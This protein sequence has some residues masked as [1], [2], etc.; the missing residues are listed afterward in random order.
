MN[1]I[2]NNLEGHQFVSENELEWR[3]E[4][5]IEK[6]K[7]QT[8]GHF[9]VGYNARLIGSD[10]P[11]FIKVLDMQSITTRGTTGAA[12]ALDAAT[13]EHSFETEILKICKERKLSRVLHATDAGLSM[14]TSGDLNTAFLYIAFERANLGAMANV[15]P[16]IRKDGIQY[17]PSVCHNLLVGLQQL[18]GVNIHHN[19]IK[20]SNIL[21]FDM[22]LQKIGDLG[23]STHPTLVPPFGDDN[24][25]AGDMS[26]MPPETMF[27]DSIRDRPRDISEHRLLTDIYMAGSTLFYAITD[28]PYNSLLISRAISNTTNI[29]DLD[30][31]EAMPHL[32]NAHFSIFKDLQ[33]K[34]YETYPRKVGDLLKDIIIVISTISHPDFKVRRTTYEKSGLQRIISKFDLMKNKMR[35]NYNRES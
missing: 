31:D 33:L 8:G 20:P 7:S 26:Y 15:L 25:H 21:F 9:S 14:V 19:D 3:F 27:S 16:E 30:Y 13:K 11:Y 18:H 10:R 17:F 35:V 22:T 1:D 23:R 28:T 29:L 24:I 32:I 6:Q 5:K 12:Q 2:A 34:I 4:N